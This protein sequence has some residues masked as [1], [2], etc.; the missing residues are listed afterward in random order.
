M[1][2]VQITRQEAVNLLT[3]KQTETDDSVFDSFG[4]YLFPTEI[5][6][7]NPNTAL[8]TSTSIDIGVYGIHSFMSNNE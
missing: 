2:T 3:D 5:T 8:G 1:K 7:K 6:L 4:N